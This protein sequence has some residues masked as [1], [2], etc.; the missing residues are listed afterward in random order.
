MAL[1]GE[2]HFVF[3]NLGLAGAAQNV[4]QL[5]TNDF[6]D[7]GAGGLQVLTGVKVIGM[8]VEVLT[9]SAGQSQTQ[10]G[11]NVDLTYAD[12]SP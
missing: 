4:D 3:L 1:R 12:R 7:V 2:G 10:V 11:V 6:L 5:V 9:N 8:L